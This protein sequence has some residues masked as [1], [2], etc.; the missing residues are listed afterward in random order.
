MNRMKRRKTQGIAK[1]RLQ[2]QKHPQESQT[3]QH[4]IHKLEDADNLDRVA[5]VMQ[6]DKLGTDAALQQIGK[7]LTDE[8]QIVRKAVTSVLTR[9][10]PRYVEFLHK[11]ALE[12]SIESRL[13]ALKLIGQDQGNHHLRALVKCADDS[14]PPE[15]QGL[16]VEIL[17]SYTDLEARLVRHFW[18]ERHHAHQERK[19]HEITVINIDT[20]DVEDTVEYHEEELVEPEYSGIRTPVNYRQ[21][22]STLLQFVREGRWNDQHTA[23][24]M[25]QKLIADIN[26]DLGAE[27]LDIRRYLI[28]NLNDPTQMV[29]WVVIQALITLHDKE[30]IPALVPHLNDPSWTIRVAVIQALAAMECRPVARNIAVC[31]DDPNA[32]VRLAAIEALGVI[33]NQSQIQILSNVLRRSNERSERIAAIEVLQQMPVLEVVPIL[34][35]VLNDDDVYIRWYASKALSVIA[36]A[37]CAQ[38]ADEMVYH[39]ADTSRPHNAEISISELIYQALLNIDSPSTRKVLERWQ[40]RT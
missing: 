36:D 12:S 23:V 24:K 8:S 10:H 38:W 40:S 21:S 6:L 5:I 16:A 15:I 3:L 27:Y 26:E 9:K 35:N 13:A 17:N 11:L 39:L 4:L 25:V 28:D 19:D 2:K 22:F 30:T 14:Q 33:G 37:S 34:M 32:T 7:L 1:E 29:R 31:V 20:D 18:F